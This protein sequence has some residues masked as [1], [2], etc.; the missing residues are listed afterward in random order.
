[1]WYFTQHTHD[2][3]LR[4]PTVA[5]TRTVLYVRAHSEATAVTWHRCERA[6]CH[7]ELCVLFKLGQQVSPEV[8]W[9]SFNKLKK[10]VVTWITFLVSFWP[11]PK[12]TLVVCG[13]SFWIC[14]YFTKDARLV[15]YYTV[16]AVNLEKTEFLNDSFNKWLATCGPHFA[17]DRKYTSNLSYPSN[18]MRGA[19]GH[20]G[21]VLKAYKTKGNC[22]DASKTSLNA[23]RVK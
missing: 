18:P 2:C 21:C 3:A 9:H 22:S 15:E 23:F 1:M 10:N 14:S 11:R 12:Y 5:T 16:L 6:R 13:V 20:V 8:L 19:L 7:D 4:Q 17:L